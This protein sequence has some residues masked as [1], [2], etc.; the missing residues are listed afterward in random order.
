M[1]PL[2]RILSIVFGSLAAFGVLAFILGFRFALR[3]AGK[4]DGELKMLFWAAAGM[5][6]LIVAGVSTAYILLPIFLHY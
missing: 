5:A 6:G 1:A 2:D 4:P 3:A